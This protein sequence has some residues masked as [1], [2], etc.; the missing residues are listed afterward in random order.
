MKENLKDVPDEIEQE[1]I[2]DIVLPFQPE[3]RCYVNRG[4][5]ITF[6]MIDAD[7]MDQYLSVPMQAARPLAGRLIAIADASDALDAQQAKGRN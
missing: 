1:D 7:G 4:G 2:E 3:I 6:R 5:G